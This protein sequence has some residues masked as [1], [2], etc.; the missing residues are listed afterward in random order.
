M[1]GM[2]GLEL[3]DEVRRREY[4][5]PVVVVA[6][7]VRTPITVRAMKGGAVTVL[8]KPWQEDELWDAI[9]LA[10]AE[11]ARVYA[12]Y[13][14]R[15]QILR[16]LTLLT[17]DERRVMQQIVEGVP[18]KGIARAEEVS[19]RTIESRRRAIFSKMQAC[20]LAALVRMAIASGIL[21]P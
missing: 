8:E 18:N 21:P 17:P 13:E 11:E 3:L 1:L 16:R 9:R 7:H 4:P 10:L 19:V 2:S 12:A 15:R 5:L 20:S 6:A 14:Y